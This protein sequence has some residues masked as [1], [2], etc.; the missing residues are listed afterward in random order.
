MRQALREHGAIDLV[1]IMVGVLVMAI[2]GGVI[3]ASV[4]VVIPW[5]QDSSA[6][7]GLDAIKTARGIQYT[8][9]SGNTGT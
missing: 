7:S 6:E 3:A 8:I 9:S 1:S 4:F 5:A 2:I